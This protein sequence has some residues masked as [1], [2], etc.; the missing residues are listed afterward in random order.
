[1]AA[2]FVPEGR[3]SWMDGWRVPV[4]LATGSGEK[5]EAGEVGEF[6]PAACK[7]C[8]HVSGLIIQFL[9]AVSMSLS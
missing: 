2:S 4:R 1:M 9:T 5:G 8:F 6:G 3:A 7:S